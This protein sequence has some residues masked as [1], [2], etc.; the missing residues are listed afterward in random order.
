MTVPVILNRAMSSSSAIAKRKSV[1]IGKKS[2]RNIRRPVDHQVDVWEFV[3]DP[4]DE[5]IKRYNLKPNS[6]GDMV[7]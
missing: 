6:N 7:H 5:L 4:S 1:I 3:L 2:W